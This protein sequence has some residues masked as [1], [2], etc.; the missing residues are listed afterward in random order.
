MKVHCDEGV[1]AARLAAILAPALFLLGAA[2]GTNGESR[3]CKPEQTDAAGVR[4]DK[5]ALFPWVQIST[6]DRSSR[7]RP[8]QAWRRRS[9]KPSDSGSRIGDCASVQAATRVSAPGDWQGV[10]GESPLR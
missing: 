10:C 6:G 9:L 4:R 1:G 3:F 2:A 5:A 8:E 7:K